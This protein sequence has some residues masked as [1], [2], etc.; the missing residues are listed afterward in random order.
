[1]ILERKMQF[2]IPDLHQQIG[3]LGSGTTAAGLES[4]RASIMDFAEIMQ[5]YGL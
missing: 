3:E 5:L 4:I 2:N 1:M